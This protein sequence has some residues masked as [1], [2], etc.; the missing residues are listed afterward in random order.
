M[1]GA[2]VVTIPVLTAILVLALAVAVLLVLV[3]VVA[4]AR[5]KS[6]ERSTAT[7]VAHA[8]AAEREAHRRFLARL[9]HELKN[10]VTAIRSALAA[11]EPLPAQN[12]QIASAQAARLADLVGELRALAS[13]ETREIDREN[14]DPTALVEEEVQ[15]VRDELLARGL[16]RDLVTALP[17][18]PWPL[19]PVLG[20]PDLLAVAV[21]NVVLNAAKY[22]DPGARIEVRGTESEGSVVI[23]VADTGWGIADEDLPHVWD[24]LFRARAARGI[25]G[26]G[27]GLSL[28][29]V[30]IERHGGQVSLRSRAGAGPSVRLEIPAAMR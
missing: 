30:V 23:E 26:S 6:R 11:G 28:V 2:F 27:L 15:A 29:R 4:P 20:D 8:T 12:V 7:A 17:T 5:R 13:L 3:L 18:V 1:S 19:P 10:P 9:D 21:R 24:E 25:E 22:S 14:V 16:Q